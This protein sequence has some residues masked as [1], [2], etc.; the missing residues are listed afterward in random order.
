MV[1]VKRQSPWQQQEESTWEP[2]R[3]SIN[4]SSSSPGQQVRF[5]WPK[6][7]PAGAGWAPPGPSAP[8]GLGAQPLRGTQ[9]DGRSSGTALPQWGSWIWIWLNRWFASGDLCQ[10]D[11]VDGS[12]QQWHEGPPDRHTAAGLMC[13]HSWNYRF[14]CLSQDL[15]AQASRS[16]SIYPFFPKKKGQT[17]KKT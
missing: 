16:Q 15:M 3:M 4:I 10:G 2:T 17:S 14:H 11:E 5:G 6:T 9:K 13:R 8:F 7:W 12:R 1:K